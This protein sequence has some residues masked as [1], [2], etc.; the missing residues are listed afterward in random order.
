MTLISLA[1]LACVAVAPG[2][3]STRVFALAAN[4]NIHVTRY[5]GG[6]KTPVV[7]VPG[8][9]G[10]AYAFRQVA[11]QLAER[12]HPVFIIDMLGAGGSSKPQR[13]DYSLT[14]QSR[15]VETVLDSL[16]ITNAIVVAQ[17]LGGSISYRLAIRRPDLVK[18]IVGIDAG[19]SEQA[20]TSGI[21]KAMKFAT[22]IKFFGAKR[23]LVGKVKD[24]LID[25]SAD[26][27]WVTPEIVKEYTAA[28]RED[29]GAMLKVLQT[30]SGT[31]EP[32]LLVPTLP[33]LKMPVLLLVGTA[34]N[35]LSAEKIE[36]LRSGMPNFTLRRVEGAGQFIHEEKP[37]AV[38]QAVVEMD[39]VVAT[40]GGRPF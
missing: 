33:N 16:G 27:A 18:S 4:E 37:D 28:Y 24:G 15:R 10:G 20:A 23:I 17:A 25:A 6:S 2:P 36:I 22:L 29:A 31:K 11:P 14:A 13:A 1:L 38:I 3:P 30:M 39:V 32:E 34:E 9:V 19:A 8:L 7:I 40:T 12:G 35:S 26:P 5:D 21:R